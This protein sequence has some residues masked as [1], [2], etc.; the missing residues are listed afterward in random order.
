MLINIKTIILNISAF[1]KYKISNLN[2][3]NTK[4]GD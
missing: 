4:K 3:V 1:V 2:L